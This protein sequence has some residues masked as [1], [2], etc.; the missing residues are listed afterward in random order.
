[1]AIDPHRSFLGTEFKRV[2]RQLTVPSLPTTKKFS[3]TVAEFGIACGCYELALLPVFA[4]DR[5]TQWM[6]VGVFR[7]P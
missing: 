2:Y 7:C 1:M 6:L 3:A 4:A 5:A